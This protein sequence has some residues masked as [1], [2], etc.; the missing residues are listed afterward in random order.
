MNYV[1][2]IQMQS[3]TNAALSSCGVFFET[4]KK[5]DLYQKVFGSIMTMFMVHLGNKGDSNLSLG[6]LLIDVHPKVGF[7]QS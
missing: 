4:H 5:I 3:Y 6:I 1:V 2:A 7:P